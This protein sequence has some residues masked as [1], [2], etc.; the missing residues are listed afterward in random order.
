MKGP[1]QHR[2]T[3]TPEGTLTWNS[4][5]T[6]VLPITG[7]K[8][9]T[10]LFMGDRWS[11]PKQA[12]AATYVWQP[13][14]VSGHSISIPGFQEA[15][16]VNTS[17]GVR[18]SKKVTDKI[19]ERADRRIS[20]SGNWQDETSNPT[21][22][23]ISQEKGASFSVSFTGTQ[24]GWY[25]QA[26]PKGGY[27][28]LILRNKKQKI[29]LSSIVDMY[30]N[31]AESSLKFLSPLLSKDDYTLTVSVLGERPNWSDK[32]KANYGSTGYE[33]SLGK[34]VLKE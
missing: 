33:V 13:L 22:G 18:S 21:A 10:F 4:Q 14:T 1:W 11:Y 20:Y 16:Q 23:R 28:K 3:F 30:C 15:W 32:R 6:F 9:T 5:T 34:I 27:A 2:G 8:D 31:Y 17:T 7:S 26:S 24:I 19:L 25:G 29:V 12:S